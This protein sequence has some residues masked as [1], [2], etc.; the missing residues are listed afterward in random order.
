MLEETLSSQSLSILHP[1][2]GVEGVA[3]E[4]SLPLKLDNNS[5]SPARGIGDED[6]QEEGSAYKVCS[7][8]LSALGNRDYRVVKIMGALLRYLL[9][10]VTC[11]TSQ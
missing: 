5:I 4:T 8:R 7:L 11:T 9:L 1:D 6:V 10:V 2:T 3:H